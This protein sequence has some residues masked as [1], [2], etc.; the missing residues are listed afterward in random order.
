MAGLSLEV[1]RELSAA[2][3]GRPFVQ[4]GGHLLPDRGWG[5]PPDDRSTTGSSTPPDLRNV[6][7]L[8]L[9]RFAGLHPT[10]RKPR[11]EISALT[12]GDQVASIVQRALDLDLDVTYRLVSLGPLFD[13]PGRQEAMFEVVLRTSRETLPPALVAALR[14]DPFTLACRRVGTRLLMQ[15]Q[16]ASALPD[17][18]LALLAERSGSDAWVFADAAFGCHI[19]TSENQGRYHNGDEL[20]RLSNR[21]E[22]TGPSSGWTGHSTVSGAPELR[23]VRASTHGAAVDAML[24]D[25]A[26]LT[27]VPDLLAGQPLADTALIARGRDHHIVL[28]PGG[29]LERLAV[30]E[31][32]YRIGPG[33]LYLPL[34]HR[35]RPTLPTAARQRLFKADEHNAIV[36]IASD[37][38]FAFDLTT[39]QPIWTLW[40]G[41]CPP[42]DLQLPAD[43]VSALSADDEGSATDKPSAANKPTRDSGNI[44]APPTASP[45][46]VN[47]P[48]TGSPQPTAGDSRLPPPG[49][50]PGLPPDVTQRP[51]RR[52]W[53]EE[54]WLAELRGD[55]VQ[56]AELHEHNRDYRRAAHLYEL[57]ARQEPPDSINSRS[58]RS[59]DR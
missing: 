48:G 29:L 35:L 9:V 1:G 38:G 17:R 13:P 53:Q 3:R 31:P 39:C 59:S 23:L 6:K 16:L 12:S 58:L 27:C 8:D 45:G 28:A 42:I 37:Q 57:A 36:L 7:L 25:D 43:I 2:A 10:A 46:P 32:L 49:V 51:Q 19:L 40:L 55:L 14:R 24:L 30:G 47:P 50:G 18:H 5:P 33:P 20:V 54:A 15:D 26:D 4:I 34:G 52:S 41:E 56:A 44:A 22:L 21:Y 11:N